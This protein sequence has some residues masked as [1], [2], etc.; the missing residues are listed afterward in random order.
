MSSQD[1]ELLMYFD[2]KIDLSM[3]DGV[4]VQ[5]IEMKSTGELKR[6][7]VIPLSE[8]S[9]KEK[10]TSLK[11]SIIAKPKKNKYF[12]QTHNIQVKMDR[13]LYDKNKKIGKRANIIGHL[14]PRLVL[15]DEEYH[16]KS[17][18]GLNINE[19]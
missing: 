16:S 15:R 18:K 9:I 6:C 11:M 17:G 8:N 14:T 10:K 5:A 13:S 3:L 19:L 4:E 7:A 12:G 2:G 1:N